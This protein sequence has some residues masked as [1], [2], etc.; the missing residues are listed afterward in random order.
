MKKILSA[1]LIGA[2]VFLLVSCAS[3]R[4]I[5]IE[6]VKR[7]NLT[8][9]LLTGECLS[10]TEKVEYYGG[11]TLSYTLYIENAE[12]AAAYSYNLIE[13]IGDYTLF[14]HEGDIFKKKGDKYC[15]VLFANQAMTYYLYIKD[16]ANDSLEVRFPLDAGERYQI[17]SETVGDNI[18]VSYYADVT[19]QIASYVY[20]T[21]LKTGDRIISDYLTDKS[22][23]ILEIEYRVEHPDKSSELVAKRT[24]EYSDKKE[25]AF[26]SLPSGDEKTVKLVIGNNVYEYGVPAGTYVEFYD[27]GLGYEYFTDKDFTEKYEI[28]ASRDMTVYVKTNFD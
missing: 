26:S 14:A 3:G 27:G 9:N 19:P 28:S 16:Y 4:S 18:H 12:N 17:M 8:G 25:G 23:R 24:F 20:S 2:T 15:T 7:A 21:K 13:S 10:Y 1:L 11:E 5:P 22:Y 6:T